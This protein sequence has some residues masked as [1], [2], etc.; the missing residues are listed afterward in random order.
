MELLTSFLMD[1]RI[2]ILEFSLLSLLI[3]LAM[4]CANFGNDC[5]NTARVN[6]TIFMLILFIT[7]IITPF[8]IDII[9]YS[10]Y[11]THYADT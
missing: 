7:R 1:A 10:Y 3:R 9:H 2:S 11:Y 5:K 8:H 6:R 4:S